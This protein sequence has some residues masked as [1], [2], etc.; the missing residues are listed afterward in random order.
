MTRIGSRVW[1][2]LRAPKK[3]HSQNCRPG[4]RSSFTPVVRYSPEIERYLLTL[5]WAKT[6]TRAL[7]SCGSLPPEMKGSAW[8]FEPS[9]MHHFIYVRWKVEMASTWHRLGFR[10]DPRG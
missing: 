1:A 4:S 7:E 8:T 2:G 9:G 6:P 3:E 10:R 5:H